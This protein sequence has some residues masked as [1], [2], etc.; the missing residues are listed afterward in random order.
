VSA[1]RASAENAIRLAILLRPEAFGLTAEEVNPL[2][3]NI[4]QL[5]AD[6]D[7]GSTHSWQDAFTECSATLHSKVVEVLGTTKAKAPAAK[8]PKAKPAAEPSSNGHGGDKALVAVGVGVDK[9]TVKQLR[10][11]GFLYR[12]LE[13][14]PDYKNDI[15]R[16]ST[17]QA[18]MRIKEL[19]KRLE[20][21]K[22][23]Q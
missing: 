4:L 20:E 11:I 18:T 22:G 21:K 23:S 10:Y 6:A 5:D 9:I 13:E 3:K 1:V 16:L 2:L 15:G 7:E 12:Q 14:E 17:T 8:K 19:E